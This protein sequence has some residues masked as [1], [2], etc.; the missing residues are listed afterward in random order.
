[1]RRFSPINPLARFGEGES[2]GELC[3]EPARTEPRPPRITKGHFDVIAAVI[4]LCVFGIGPATYA[5]E[6]AISDAEDQPPAQAEA[7]RFHPI[8]DEQFKRALFGRV[9]GA[10][11]T[12]MHFEAYF[13]SRIHEIDQ[14]YGLVPEHKK[15]LEVVARHEIQKFFDSV[16]EAKERFNRVGWDRLER[17]AISDELI[18]FR[19][20]INS[21]NPSI[22]PFFTK[23]LRKILADEQYRRHVNGFVRSRV[24]RAVSHFDKRLGLSGEQHRCSVNLIAD[25]TPPLKQYGEY[26]TYALLFQ[27]SKLPEDKFRPILGDEQSHRLREL[28]LE[29]RGYKETLIAKGYITSDG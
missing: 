10:E 3:R 29:V 22:A 2:P 6:A 11:S 7:P 9:G 18:A 19:I 23:T 12:R 13:A 25:E 26:D 21:E 24:D 8:T 27:A 20:Q 16:H 15:K 14:S 4:L 28:F 5:Q 17:R 1:M